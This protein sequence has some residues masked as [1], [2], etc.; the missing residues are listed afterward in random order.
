MDPGFDCLAQNLLFVYNNMPPF[1][2]LIVVLRLVL[3]LYINKVTI[4]GIKLKKV[5][6]LAARLST[7]ANH[8][9][10]NL[11]IA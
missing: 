1:V 10:L 8:K 3:C 5:K 7:A 6:A 11:A 9:T 4:E 2:L